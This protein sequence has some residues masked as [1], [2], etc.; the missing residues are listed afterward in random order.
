MTKIAD[1]HRKYTE[2]IRWKELTQLSDEITSLIEHYGVYEH[3]FDYLIKHIKE[4]LYSEEIDD[5][6]EE[7]D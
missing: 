1:R 4:M 2:T 6:L 5:E 7:D 3:E